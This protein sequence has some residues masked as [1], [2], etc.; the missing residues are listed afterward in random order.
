VELKCTQNR[1]ECQR[2]EVRPLRSASAPSHIDKN[3]DRVV[4]LVME[5]D[6]IQM[7]P[8]LHCDERSHLIPERGGAFK[9]LG[10]TAAIGEKLTLGDGVNQ[11]VIGERVEEELDR[12]DWCQSLGGCRHRSP[13]AEK[14]IPLDTGHSQENSASAS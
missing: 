14:R 1:H 6:R 10:A 4:G 9:I 3:N 12:A 2:M 7:E 5:E 11:T 13:R 8:A